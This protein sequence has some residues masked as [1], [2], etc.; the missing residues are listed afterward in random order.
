ME[1]LI[2]GTRK[3]R[4]TVEIEEELDGY[5]NITKKEVMERTG[6]PAREDGDSQAWYDYVEEAVKEGAN[7][8]NPD[9]DSFLKGK[10]SKVTIIS[11]SKSQDVVWKNIDV[12]W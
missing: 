6:C 2:T 1:F 12:T 7:Q 4:I 8:L 10:D 9:N 11:E 3:R 5:F